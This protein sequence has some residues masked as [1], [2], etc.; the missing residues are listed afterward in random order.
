MTNQERN[1]RLICIKMDRN[2]IKKELKWDDIKIARH[3]HTKYNLAVSTII[4]LFTQEIYE[5]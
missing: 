5:L 1:E 3:L 2:K 4:N